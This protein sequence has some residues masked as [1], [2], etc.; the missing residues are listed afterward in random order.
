MYHICNLQTILF[1]S[2]E[3]VSNTKCILKFFSRC[4]G[5]HINMEK[6]SLVGINLDDNLADTF[7]SRMGCGVGSW[8][9]KY[10]VLPLGGNLLSLEFWR[11]VIEKV[12]RRLDGW[13][14]GFLS[15]GGRVTLI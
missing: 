7:A 8:P 10:L 11:P 4:S 1:A 15:R 9:I 13:K 6:S 2:L 12:A 14:K 5:L 3:N